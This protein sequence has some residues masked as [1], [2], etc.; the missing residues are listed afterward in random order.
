MM[1]SHNISH[2]HKLSPLWIVNFSLQKNYIFYHIKWLHSLHKCICLFLLIKWRFYIKA[3][4][5]CLYIFVC[6]W[7]KNCGT[8]QK[9]KGNCTCVFLCTT[10][11]TK[12]IA[13]INVF[14]LGGKIA[15]PQKK[16]RWLHVRT[17]YLST[18]WHKYEFSNF[19]ISNFYWQN[20][21]M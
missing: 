7:W 21:S 2:G 3:K 1:Q 6:S 13:R 18:I 9:T 4:D 10:K 5:D 8:T 20:T 12:L 17:K 15:A 14:V 11:K 19:Q 16:P